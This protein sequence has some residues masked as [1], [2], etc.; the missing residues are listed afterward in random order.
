MPKDVTE[1]WLN[2]LS[3]SDLQRED[4][5]EPFH[6]VTAPDEGHGN[7]ALRDAT[8]NHWDHKAAPQL[9]AW[10]V[11]T[12]KFKQAFCAPSD[13][14]AADAFDVV[15]NLLQS[16]KSLIDP[17]EQA[18]IEG[19]AEKLR[20]STKRRRGSSGSV[21]TGDMPK[22][23]RT[24]ISRSARQASKDHFAVNP[25][26]DA[27]TT[28]IL[29]TSTGLI[30]KTIRTWFANKRSRHNAGKCEMFYRNPTML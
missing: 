7:G 12:I 25:H 3:T 11:D 5:G 23:G 1:D 24:R 10:D 13:Q 4:P 18:V 26:L 29:S 15:E 6:P 20:A 8:L 22:A 19:L 27:G 21:E 14:L 16:G 9:D 30:M 2:T 17:H 28:A